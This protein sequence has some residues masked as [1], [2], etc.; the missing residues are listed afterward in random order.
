MPC[1]PSVTAVSLKN[2]EIPLV[3]EDFDIRAA[4]NIKG[5]F[6]VPSFAEV[7]SETHYGGIIAGCCIFIV[8]IFICAISVLCN[9]IVCG[10]LV[11]CGVFW[12]LGLLFIGVLMLLDA[13]KAR[14]YS[15]TYDVTRDLASDN[16][17]SNKSILHEVKTEVVAG[18]LTAVTPHA[19]I[20]NVDQPNVTLT[21]CGNI[22]KRYDNQRVLQWYNANTGEEEEEVLQPGVELLLT[23]LSPSATEPGTVEVRPTSESLGAPVVDRVYSKITF[24]MAEVK[25][26]ANYK[27]EDEERRARSVEIEGDNGQ[28]I[29]QN[30]RILS[31]STITCPQ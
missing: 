30:N 17:R 19:V 5:N 26:V 8:A 1:S 10:E 7:A 21:Y 3:P 13:V 15:D 28:I 2:Q 31:L 20:G 25:S 24:N 11:C 9:S 27:D 14:F 4:Y 6:L 16:R 23:S 29:R 12:P 22:V 18:R